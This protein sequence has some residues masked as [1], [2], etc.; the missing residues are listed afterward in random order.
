[1]QGYRMNK[2]SVRYTKNYKILVQKIKEV[3]GR[4]SHVHGSDSI[5]LI[6][7][8]SPNRSADSIKS[9]AVF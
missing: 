6:Q 4:P 3:S 8:Y 5:L 1:M 9:P 2:T 7:Q